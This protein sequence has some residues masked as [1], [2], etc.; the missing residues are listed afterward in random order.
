MDEPT[1]SM[2]AATEKVVIDNLIEW[3][4][5]KTLIAITHRNTLIR[6]VSRVMVL[7][8]GV[9]VADDKPEKFMKS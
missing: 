5:D 3:L 6:L 1:S 8:K 9:L 4:G 2:D 7:D